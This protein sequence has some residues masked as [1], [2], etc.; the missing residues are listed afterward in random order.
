MPLLIELSPLRR[1]CASA[2]I[3]I[4]V[5]HAAIFALPIISLMITPPLFRRHY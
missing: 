2:D 3:I 5:F 1:H 4:F